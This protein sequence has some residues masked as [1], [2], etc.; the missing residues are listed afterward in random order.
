MSQLGV[1]VAIFIACGDAKDATG[2]DLRLRVCGVNWIAWVGET[3]VD[4]ANKTESF[5][6]FAKEQQ[7]TVRGEGSANEIDFESLSAET[8]QLRSISIT[9]C[10]CQ[11]PWLRG[12]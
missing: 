5:V 9:L 2:K 8:F 12:V 10:Q 6:D 4:S 11:E 3:R 7:S 1:I